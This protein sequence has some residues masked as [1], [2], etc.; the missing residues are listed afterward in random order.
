MKPVRVVLCG[1]YEKEE[2]EKFH[3]TALFDSDD[4]DRAE[5][6]AKK[7]ALAMLAIPELLDR[8]ACDGFFIDVYA[9]AEWLHCTSFEVVPGRDLV[10]WYGGDCMA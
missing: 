8:Y 10:V 4:F 5:S 7:I 2:R 3:I 9:V 6:Q 1:F